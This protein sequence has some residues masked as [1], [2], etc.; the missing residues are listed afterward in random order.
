MG[1]DTAGLNL[2]NNIF[3]SYE[4]RYGEYGHHFF[5]GLK[6]TLNTVELRL[7][8]LVNPAYNFVVEAGVSMRKYSNAV[9]D[10]R[11]DVFYF[12]IRTS[13]ENYYFDF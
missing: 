10:Q 13:L 7:N 12:G 5:D 2:G 11:S 8:Y 9:Q 4:T 1:K 6:S 3:D